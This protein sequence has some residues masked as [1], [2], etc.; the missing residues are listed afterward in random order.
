[1]FG[2]RL[3][4]ASWNTCP[5]LV[6]AQVAPGAET[7]TCETVWEGT[8]SRSPSLSP[9]NK[10]L[11]ARLR[12]RGPSTGWAEPYT[13]R[14]Q[15]LMDLPTSRLCPWM[16]TRR[17]ARAYSERAAHRTRKQSL[18]ILGSRGNVVRAGKCSDRNALTSWQLI[19][20]AS[21]WPTAKA[22]AVA[23]PG[24]AADAKVGHTSILESRARPRFS[25]EETGF[26]CLHTSKSSNCVAPPVT[27]RASTVS[28]TAK[29]ARQHLP[30]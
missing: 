25:R 19:Q 28:I 11:Q 5:H 21:I 26:D 14:V 2:V 10:V 18:I 16:K 15:A 12:G 23:E 29:R 1:M 30:V 7:R 3:R 13:Q 8:P 4:I 17:P 24:V 22:Y 20:T 27:A 9:L 6:C